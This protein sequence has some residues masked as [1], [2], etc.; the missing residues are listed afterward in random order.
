MHLTKVDVFRC[1]PFAGDPECSTGSWAPAT[2]RLFVCAALLLI[3]PI[4]SAALEI[5]FGLGTCLPSS[6]CYWSVEVRSDRSGSVD[7]DPQRHLSKSFTVSRKSFEEIAKVIRRE[8]FF[9][10]PPEVGDWPVDGPSA[11]IEIKDGQQ[12][13]KVAI[14]KLPEEFQA[15]WKTD[16]GAIGRAFRLCEAVRSLA[17]TDEIPHCWGLPAE[18]KN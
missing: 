15:I 10:L 16:V 14:G 2:S 9:S 1:T 13:H 11:W 5:K 8:Q 4:T 6:L 17:R 18:R 3:T 12:H 7:A